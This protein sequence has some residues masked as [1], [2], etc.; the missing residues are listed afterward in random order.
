MQ[1]NASVKDKDK[2][3]HMRQG[4]RFAPS[5][6]GV[7]LVCVSFRGLG[8]LTVDDDEPNSELL[9]LLVDEALPA[10]SGADDDDDSAREQLPPEFLAL[11]RALVDEALVLVHLPDELE[12]RRLRLL[13]DRALPLRRLQRL[14]QAADHALRQKVRAQ[15]PRRRRNGRPEGSLALAVAGGGIVAAPEESRLLNRPRGELG[16][17]PGRTEGLGVVHE[18]V[19]GPRVPARRARTTLAQA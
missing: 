6:A 2:H 7:F 14:R 13:A 12:G 9:G 8:P 17:V 5:S 4:I 1:C 16:D 18:G 3:R 15:T 19:A 11:R 10:V